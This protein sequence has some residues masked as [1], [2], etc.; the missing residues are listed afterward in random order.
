ELD[1]DWRSETRERYELKQSVSTLEDQMQG[2]MLED[3]EE[4]ERLKKK[5]KVVQEE[6]EQL[7]QALRYVVVWIREYFRGEIPLSVDEERP[8]KANDESRFSCNALI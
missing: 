1:T 8:T 4:K 7:E 5:L 3:R 6:N 2:F